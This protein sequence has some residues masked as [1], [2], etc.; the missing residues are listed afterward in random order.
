MP[1]AKKLLGMGSAREDLRMIEGNHT[2]SPLIWTACANWNANA[3]KYLAREK[4]YQMIF[5]HFHNVDLQGQ[6]MLLSL[7]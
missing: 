6:L 4:G 5:S 1:N 2:V 7:A 3:I